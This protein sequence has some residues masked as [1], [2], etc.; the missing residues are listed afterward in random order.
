[1]I[2]TLDDYGKRTILGCQ[3][4]SLLKNYLDTVIVGFG[5]ADVLGLNVNIGTYMNKC[6]HRIS[7]PHENQ[8]VHEDFFILNQM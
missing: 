4:K 7:K 5:Q 1:M 6:Q 8:L 2:H 3:L